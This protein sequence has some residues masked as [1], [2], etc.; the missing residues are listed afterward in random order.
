MLVEIRIRKKLWENWF[1]FVL[2][3]K[4]FRWMSQ[5]S[6]QSRHRYFAKIFLYTLRF[7]HLILV[8][9]FSFK[10]ESQRNRIRSREYLTTKKYLETS[11]IRFVHDSRFVIGIKSWTALWGSAGGSDFCKQVCLR[12]Q[13]YFLSEVDESRLNFLPKQEYMRSDFLI[14]C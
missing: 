8:L 2:R 1:V 7:K 5:I 10:K 9:S 12:A 14:E 3:L 13:L 11:A 4:G 6:I